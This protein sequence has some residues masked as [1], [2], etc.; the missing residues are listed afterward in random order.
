MKN[1]NWLKIY[2]S[3]S[4]VFDFSLFRVLTLFTPAYL[5]EKIRQSSTDLQEIAARHEYHRSGKA[6]REVY[7]SRDNSIEM[8]MTKRHG[9]TR[10]D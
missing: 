4:V 5:F 3:H 1:K 6:Q 7:R 9:R 10:R 8:H 2:Y